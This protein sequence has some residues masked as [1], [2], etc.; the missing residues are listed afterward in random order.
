M[1]PPVQ[2]VS[3]SG[4]SEQAV[5]ENSNAG[6][7]PVASIPVPTS[8]ATPT[9]AAPQTS[10]YTIPPS[11]GMGLGVGLIAAAPTIQ[12]VLTNATIMPLSN[13]T[14]GGVCSD[15]ASLKKNVS[16]IIQQSSLS[17]SSNYYLYKNIS[18]RIDNIET[19]VASIQT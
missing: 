2:P 17:M 10:G 4:T 13:C 6:G 11:T 5:T 7:V 9:G 16:R 18:T 19:Q 12:P 3:S 8:S 15:L 14:L 1:V